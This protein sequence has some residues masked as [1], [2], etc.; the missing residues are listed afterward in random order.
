VAEP[1]PAPEPEPEA[2]AVVEEVDDDVDTTEE[3]EDEVIVE[4]AV[5]DIADEL[6]DV[7]ISGIDIPDPDATPSGP[8]GGPKRAPAR[9]KPLAPRKPG[10]PPRAVKP[11]AEED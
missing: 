3:V 2:S 11:Q 8:E 9:R 4:D 6:S 1:E 10:V 7:D 5:D